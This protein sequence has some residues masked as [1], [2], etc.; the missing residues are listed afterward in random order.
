[1]LPI[2]VAPAQ[3]AHLDTEDQ[4]DMLHGNFG[5]DAV[6]SAP[7]F[8]RLSAESLVIVDDQYTVGGPS[9]CDRVVD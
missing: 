4:T 5:R 6:K 8:G 9:Q 1:V 2:L 3:P 7:V